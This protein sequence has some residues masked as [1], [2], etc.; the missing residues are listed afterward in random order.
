M[1]NL[2]RGQTV[3]HPAFDQFVAPDQPRVRERRHAAGPRDRADDVARRRSFRGSRN[4]GSGDTTRIP[5]SRAAWVA[6]ATP[7][8]VS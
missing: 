5:K 7:A 2:D 1:M 4:L 3:T 6:A 8:M